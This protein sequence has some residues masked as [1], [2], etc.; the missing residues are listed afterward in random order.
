MKEGPV[1]IFV[2]GERLIEAASCQESSQ[3]AGLCPPPPQRNMHKHPCV[4][5]QGIRFW[6]VFPRHYHAH[7]PYQFTSRLPCPTQLA[8]PSR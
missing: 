3:F 4:P 6:R 5:A 2:I 8:G 1:E 7:P